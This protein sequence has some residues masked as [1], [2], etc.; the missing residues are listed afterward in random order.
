MELH[1]IHDNTEQLIR[2][3]CDGHHSHTF[4]LQPLILPKNREEQ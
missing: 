4:D 2:V 1:L 3:H